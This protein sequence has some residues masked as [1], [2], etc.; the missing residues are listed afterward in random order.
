MPVSVIGCSR[1]FT[2]L[3]AQ[4][5]A[6][7]VTDWPEYSNCTKTSR[8]ASRRIGISDGYT[9]TRMRELFSGRFQTL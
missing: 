5:D 4:R 9:Y 1:R 2:G 7:Q 8:P 6:T 3:L